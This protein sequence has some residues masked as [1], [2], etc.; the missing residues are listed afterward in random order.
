MRSR[1]IIL[2]YLRQY[3]AFALILECDALAWAQTLYS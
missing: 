1:F 2:E 3:S